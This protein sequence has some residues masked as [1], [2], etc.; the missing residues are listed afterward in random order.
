LD[1]TEMTALYLVLFCHFLLKLCLLLLFLLPFFLHLLLYQGQLRYTNN[2]LASRM[3][4]LG[5]SVRAENGT[6]TFTALQVFAKPGGCCDTARPLPALLPPRAAFLL[7][8]PAS[9]PVLLFALAS[10]APAPL[11][12]LHD[13]SCMIHVYIGYMSVGTS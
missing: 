4:L 5:N 8:P 9:L 7:P 12:F 6:A 3:A 13:V 10:F 2:T 1:V 11:P